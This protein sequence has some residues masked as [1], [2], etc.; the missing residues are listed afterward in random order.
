MILRLTERR[1]IPS[2]LVLITSMVWATPNAGAAHNTTSYSQTQAAVSRVL[3][4]E[5]CASCH[6]MNL[7]GNESGPALSDEAF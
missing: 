4:A 6:R 3:Y 7:L 5:H 1:L 2:A